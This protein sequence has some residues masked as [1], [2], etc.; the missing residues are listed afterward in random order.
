M[1]PLGSLRYGARRSGWGHDVPAP[2]GLAPAQIE[3]LALTARRLKLA[4]LLVALASTHSIQIYCNSTWS[5]VT[6]DQPCLGSSIV[7]GSTV[8]EHC[9]KTLTQAVS[10]T[11]VNKRP[12]RGQQTSK[13]GVRKWGSAEI[14]SVQFSSFSEDH[15]SPAVGVLRQLDIVTQDSSVRPQTIDTQGAWQAIG[16][17]DWESGGGLSCR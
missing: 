10:V 6:A 5:Q 3:A 16:A 17:K 1:L 8:V 14:S 4:H 13:A 12:R 7:S 15:V 2:F 9:D 11:K